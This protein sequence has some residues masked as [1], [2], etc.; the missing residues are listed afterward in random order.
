MCGMVILSKNLSYILAYG[1]HGGREV[2]IRPSIL[3][4]GGVVMECKNGI[5]PYFGVWGGMEVVMF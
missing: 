5:S 4:M 3:H 2:V 1:W